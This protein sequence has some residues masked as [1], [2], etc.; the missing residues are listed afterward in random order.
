MKKLSLL[1][2]FMALF[3][4]GNELVGQSQS[5]FGYQSCSFS[6][7]YSCYSC[8]NCVWYAR[9][10]ADCRW[11]VQINQTGNANTWAST[12]VN[13]G[14]RISPVPVVNSIACRSLGQYGHVAWVEEILPNNMIRVSEM[15]YQADPGCPNYGGSGRRLHDYNASFFNAGFILPP[16]KEMNQSLP[17]FGGS[18]FNPKPLDLY[19][20]NSS[21]SANFNPSMLQ[22][23]K[24]IDGNLELNIPTGRLVANNQVHIGGKVWLHLTIALQPGDVSALVNSHNYRSVFLQLNDNGT[25]RKYQNDYLYFLD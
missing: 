22:S 17:I 3:Q 9:N 18:V 23:I 24:I 11:G 20:D 14:Y 25:P 21:F 13:Q 7:P 12:A 2:C 4:L 15:N 5:C 8:G 16:W 19:I 1:F 10:Q 6:N